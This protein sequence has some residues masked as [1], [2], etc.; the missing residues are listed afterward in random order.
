MSLEEIMQAPSKE[1]L[2]VQLNILNPM[3]ADILD[4]WIKVRRH[5]MINAEIAKRQLEKLNQEVVKLHR[6]RMAA[7]DSSSDSEDDWEEVSDDEE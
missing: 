6:S 3:V 7:Q 2:T 4:C 5:R 1:E